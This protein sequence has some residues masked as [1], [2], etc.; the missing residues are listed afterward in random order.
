MAPRA[1]KQNPKP[2]TATLEKW[3]VTSVPIEQSENRGPLRIWGMPVGGSS[4]NKLWRSSSI[5]RR[6]SSTTLETRFHTRVIL[7]G[8]MDSVAALDATMTQEAVDAFADGFPLAW[9]SIAAKAFTSIPRATRDTLAEL[10]ILPPTS[11]KNAN[12]KKRASNATKTKAKIKK[13]N[14]K[15]RISTGRKRGRNTTSVLQTIPIEN[16]LPNSKRSRRAT[17]PP[18]QSYRQA[19]S[20]TMGRKSTGNADSRP[21][22]PPR[23][24]ND[25]LAK[26]DNGDVT[27]AKSGA[28]RTFKRKYSVVTPPVDKPVEMEIASPEPSPPVIDTDEDD[29]STPLPGDNPS[30]KNGESKDDD[31]DEYHTPPMEQI[32]NP[33]RAKSSPK[34]PTRSSPVKVLAEEKNKRPV[35]GE[36]TD[37][38]AKLRDSADRLMMIMNQ[39][40]A[41]NSRPV[42]TTSQAHDILDDDMDTE[43]DEA[44]SDTNEIP[45]SALAVR[46][47][48][49]RNNSPLAFNIDEMT[50]PHRPS[51]TKKKPA[52]VAPKPAASVAIPENDN[53]VPMPEMQAPVELPGTDKAQKHSSEKRNEKAGN[54]RAPE[55]WSFDQLLKNREGEVR[56]G[57]PAFPEPGK[58]KVIPVESFY[59]LQMPTPIYPKKKTTSRSR[60]DG[61]RTSAPAPAV[62][63]KK[64]TQKTAAETAAK[65]KTATAAAAV[66][67]TTQPKKRAADTGA[68]SSNNPP[69]KRRKISFKD[70]L[71]EI[72]DGPQKQRS[73]RRAARM[74]KAALS[75]SA[76]TPPAK[77]T[78][79]AT[80][81]VFWTDKQ[82]EA[83]DR[84]RGE[85]PTGSADFWGLVAV[86]VEGRTEQECLERWWDYIETPEKKKTNKPKKKAAGKSTPELALDY[87]QHGVTK[88][89]TKTAK[90]T[91]NMRRIVDANARDVV[92]SQEQVYE[93]PRVAGYSPTTPV[94]MFPSDSSS[95]ATPGTEARE[96]RKEME[97]PKFDTPEPFTRN[98]TGENSVADRIVAQF[99]KRF[100]SVLN[101]AVPV[102]DEAPAG[103]KKK[104]NGPD[105]EDVLREMKTNI[106]GDENNTSE[107]GDDDERESDREGVD[108]LI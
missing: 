93:P 29:F 4:T 79:N 91:S 41:Q 96:R 59:T 45:R 61:R 34:K 43:E 99:K 17:E 74:A 106:Q 108:T 22:R 75:S 54:K 92:A 35:R 72:E 103:G 28:K 62:S 9:K 2:A 44:L 46:N 89:H 48:I 55:R 104:A 42:E 60:G 90:F 101:A 30:S 3:F 14:D 107:S 24:T 68:G 78:A 80:T 63:K 84:M 57:M 50:S 27:K 58:R 19:P 83:F 18:P 102:A 53:P 31:D 33:I 7:K 71:V 105:M 95:L 32:P 77:R 23:R 66:Q 94:G 67:K 87:A 40:H 69:T 86:G 8:P 36:S 5:V 82:I 51:K 88:A 11:G 100:G 6:I 12:P 20:K 21:S 16:F 25:R 39:Q 64:K 73:G 76:A 38:D 49:L 81:G 70:Q 10:P 65:N 56:Q 97:P 15:S 26:L 1:T 52:P 37:T 98:N 85:I 47:S 13:K